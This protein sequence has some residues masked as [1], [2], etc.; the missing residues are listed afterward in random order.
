LIEMETLVVFSISWLLWTLEWKCLW[1]N[2]YIPFRYIMSSGTAGSAECKAA[3]FSTSL[4]L[5]VLV[6]LMIIV[7]TKMREYLLM[8]LV[9]V[10][11][12]ISYAGYFFMYPFDIC[13]SPFEKCLLRSLAHSSVKSFG[14]FFFLLNFWNYFCFLNINPLCSLSLHFYCSHS[15]QKI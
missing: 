8:V 5:C 12:I 3:F 15:V 11:L 14:F 9:W 4:L 6:K 13:I 7:L 1:H 10:C 2:N